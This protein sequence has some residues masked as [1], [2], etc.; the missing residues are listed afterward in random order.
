M[1]GE[2]ISPRSPVSHSGCSLR[3]PECREGGPLPSQSPIRA[4]CHSLLL[5]ALKARPQSK[6][7]GNPLTWER[8][9]FGAGGTGRL[10]GGPLDDSFRSTRDPAPGELLAVLL[11]GVSNGAGGEP[12][13]R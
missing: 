5:A 11:S 13:C 6:A 9:Q 1:P 3:F 4:A 8:M 2:S 10:G 7:A 12:P